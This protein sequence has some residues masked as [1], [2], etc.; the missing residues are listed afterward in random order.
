MSGSGCVALQEQLSTTNTLIERGKELPSVSAM[1]GSQPCNPVCPGYLEYLRDA[2]SVLLIRNQSE[3][4][5]ALEKEKPEPATHRLR[6]G[7]VVGSLFGFQITEWM[8]VAIIAGFFWAAS[9]GVNTLTWFKKD[10]HSEGTSSVVLT[11]GVA[12][13]TAGESK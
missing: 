1:V 6:V 2:M 5:N 8:A 11:N 10:A 9:H 4:S 13:C 7:R 3:I 12:T